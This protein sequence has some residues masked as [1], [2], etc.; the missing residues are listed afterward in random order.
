MALALLEPL[1]GLDERRLSQLGHMCM[2][3]PERVVSS[4]VFVRFDAHVGHIGSFGP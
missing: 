1:H 2:P 4:T 3:L